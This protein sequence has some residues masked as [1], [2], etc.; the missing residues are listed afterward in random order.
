[1][2]SFSVRPGSAPRS[3]HYI[4]PEHRVIS[5]AET[6]WPN[7]EKAGLDAIAHL[8]FM[9]ENF[10]DQQVVVRGIQGEHLGVGVRR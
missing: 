10:V 1:V 4:E 8:R 3:H 5:S 2:F 9:Q 6:A 7:G